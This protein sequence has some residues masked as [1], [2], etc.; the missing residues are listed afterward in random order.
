MK[1]QAVAE[2]KRK[3]IE[4]FCGDTPPTEADPILLVMGKKKTTNKIK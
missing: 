1:K 2:I 3:I 4:K